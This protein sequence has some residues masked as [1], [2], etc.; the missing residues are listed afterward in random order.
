M[1]RLY[2]SIAATAL[3]ISG[4]ENKIWDSHYQEIP[5]TVDQDIWEVIQ[6]DPDLSEFTGFIKEFGYDSLFAGNH[7]YTLFIPTN[8]A[9]ASFL[10]TGTVTRVMLDY[11][12]SLHV[13]QSMNITGK[14]KIQTLGEKFALFEKAG[15]G[16]TFDGVDL[17]F[18]SPLYRNGKYYLLEE[19]VVPKPNLYEFFAM[20]NPVLKD[21]IDQQDSIILDR[22]LSRPIGFDE[23]GN[24]VYDTVSDVINLFEEEFF[25]VSEEYRY[26]TATIVFPLEED[27][28]AALTEMAVSIPAYQD[29]TDIPLK[30]QYEVLIPYLMEHGVFENMV[31]EYEFVPLPGL[32]TLKMKNI[33]GDSVVIEYQLGEKS[34]CSNGYAYNYLD[35]QVPD[36]LFTGSYRFEGEWLLLRTGTNKY[37]WDV[38][39]VEVISDVAY[40]PLKELVPSAS[41]DSVLS[42]YFTK[43]YDGTFSVEFNVETIFPREYLMVINTKMYTGG[44]YDIYVND[45]LVKTMDYK[46]F[47]LYRGI[48][49][50]D[51]GVDVYVGDTQGFNRF[52]CYIENKEAYGTTRIRFE[53]MGD[54]NVLN[55]GFVIDYIEF[56][57]I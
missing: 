30:W 17:T 21:Y 20:N 55:N 11:Q 7:T 27:Y 51:N 26:K 3:I 39:E 1:K 33:L 18:E 42:V 57:P 40:Q 31:E 19:V 13:I 14:Q 37:S 5:E 32:D 28:N 44:V 50:S 4:C 53:Y 41:N 46:L 16:T 6:A 56:F 52:D 24:T 54:G 34:L 47:E 2:L 8:G 45:E 23:D 43:G 29:H 15:N 22:E 38:E 10:D 35:F 25:P 9:Y 49:W 12:I 48:Y 36:T